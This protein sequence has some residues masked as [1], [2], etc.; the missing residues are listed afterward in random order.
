MKQSQDDIVLAE[1]NNELNIE[2]VP[3]TAR[4]SV[5]IISAV[6]SPVWTRNGFR[7][8]DYC[9]VTYEVS[10]KSCS[11]KIY[12]VA[13]REFILGDAIGSGSIGTHTVRVSTLRGTWES[14]GHIH[15]EY[16]GEWTRYYW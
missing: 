7:Y 2:L 6:F 4:P 13:A 3:I 15:L 5:R 9:D 8:C 1:G 12:V 14:T 16:D 10:G 11:I